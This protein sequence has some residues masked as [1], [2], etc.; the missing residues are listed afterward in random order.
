MLLS[1]LKQTPGFS[2]ADIANVCNESA[3]IAARKNKTVVESQDFLDAI[4]RIVGG[5]ERKKQDH[6]DGREE[7]HCLSRSRSCHSELAA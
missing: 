5:L 6:L 1:W 2:G 4:D 7:N 3:L